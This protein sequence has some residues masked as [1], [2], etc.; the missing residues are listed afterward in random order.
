MKKHILLTIVLSL[1]FFTGRTFGQT[2]EIIEAIVNKT[3]IPKQGYDTNDDV[4]FVAE[5]FLPNHCFSLIKAHPQLKKETQS[6]GS[7][8][9]VFEYKQLAQRDIQGKCAD[10][11]L[12]KPENLHLT[13][14]RPFTSVEVF[15]PEVNFETVNSSPYVG[16][17]T[18]RTFVGDKHSD[19]SFF[20]DSAQSNKKDNFDYAG[21][22]DVT[23]PLQ[24]KK[25]DELKIQVGAWLSNSC[26]KLEDNDLTYKLLDDVIVVKPIIRG[27]IGQG[28]LCLQVMTLASPT[29]TIKDPLDAGRYLV[30]TRSRD[31]KGWNNTFSVTAY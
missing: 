3:F 13:L 1:N 27:V 15:L 29:I 9:R 14:P 6:D 30:H 28:Q 2:P 24:V 25:G 5:G 7:I 21:V 16:E 31:G 11:E 23:V 8:K 4:H 12:K 10:S 18:I 17:Y 20:V 22:L 19:R 26:Q